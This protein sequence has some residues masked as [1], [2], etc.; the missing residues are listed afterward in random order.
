LNIKHLC[1]ILSETKDLVRQTTRSFAN[2]QDDK[3][4]GGWQ[5]ND[6]LSIQG[7]GM[8]MESRYVYSHL[9]SSSIGAEV[10]CIIVGNETY[11]MMN[12]EGFESDFQRIV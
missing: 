7:S 3:I 9:V 1:V 11:H 8:T 5:K 10:I 2:A 12:V 4:A 6:W